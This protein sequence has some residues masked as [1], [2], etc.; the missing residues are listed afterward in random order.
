LA[1]GLPDVIIT[2]AKDKYQ[3]PEDLELNKD[4]ISK[5]VKQGSKGGKR[6]LQ[7]PMLEVEPYLVELIIKLA[8]MRTPITTSQGLQLANSLIKG[9]S[10]E[11]KVNE[12][13]KKYCKSFQLG[14][15]K[16]E[17]DREYWQQ[18]MKRNE[19]LIRSKKAVKFNVKCAKWCNYSNMLEMYQEIYK[20]FCSAGVACEHPEPLWWNE[21]GEIMEKEDEAFGCKSQYELIH[22]EWVLFVE[23]CGS[24][25]SQAKDGQ[26]GGQTYLSSRTGRPQQR[27]ATKDAHFTVMGFTAASGDPVMCAI[28]FAAKVFKDE[29]RTGVEPF[30]EW[31][32]EPNNL[33]DN[34]GDGKMY[35]FGLGCFVKG[36]H[37]PCFCCHSK[38]G[39]ITGH[40][41]T[42]MLKCLDNLQ[43]FDRE[44][45]GLNPFLILDGHGS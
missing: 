36:K 1:K 19:H 7:S 27:A 28:I 15:G 12:W 10:V 37:I 4:T 9:T 3:I 22:P 45:S 30:A 14:A 13:K 20:D 21:K 40:L 38:S 44:N 23:E 35:P 34:C 17:L 31:I 5:R 43:V 25:T 41:L 11:E 6:G 39:S 29:W 26:V 18:F 2:A 8:D 16:P 42:E 32:A 24:N 33:V